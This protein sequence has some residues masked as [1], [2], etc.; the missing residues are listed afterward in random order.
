MY[1]IIT[2]EFF[3][4][5]KQLLVTGPGHRREVLFRF[6]SF[7]VLLKFLRGGDPVT[8]HKAYRMTSD[9]MKLFITLDGPQVC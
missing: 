4:V 2:V 8:E 7:V 9:Q 6:I 3:E 1:A 5:V